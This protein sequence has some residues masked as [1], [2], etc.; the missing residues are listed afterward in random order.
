MR[1]F[2]HDLGT[3][4]TAILLFASTAQAQT[5]PQGVQQGPSIAGI[6]EYSYPNGLRVLLLPDPGSSAITVNI[7]YLVGSRHEN[8][9]ETG[10]AHLLE[11]LLFIESTTGRNI[12]EE[13]DDHGARWNGTTWFDRTNYFETVNASDENL[14]WALDLEAERMVHMRVDREVLEAE[15]TVVRN[16]FER[17]ENRPTAVLE[18][19]VF[20]TAYLWHNY[21][22]STIGARSDIENVTPERVAAFYATYYQP[23]NA[24]VTIAGPIDPSETLA[25]VAATLGAI[26]RPQRILDATYTVEPPQDGER[27]VDL[28]RAGSGQNL[29]IAYHI[30][31]RAHPDV[32]ALA[33]LADILTG[34]GTG[35]LNRSLEDTQKALSV[36][37]DV[38]ELHD[39]GL[40]V[41][42]ATLNDQ[43]SLDEVKAVIFD[44]LAGLATAPPTAEEVDRAKT[45]I[46]QGIDRTLADARRLALRLNE[47]IASG[48]WR[49][50][51]TNY[52]QVRQVASEDVQGVAARYFKASNR[53]VGAFIA[54]ATPDRTLVPEA[55][56]IA[57]LLET[58]T[59]DI[60]VAAGEA[61][62][63]APVNLENRIER[64]TVNEGIRVALVPKDTR[65][66]RVAA[67]LTLRFGDEH[68][69]VGQR[70]VSD[71]ANALLMRG[72]QTKSRQAIQDEM[73]RLNATIRVSG[74]RSSATASIA[75]TEEHFVPALRL[76]VEIL[77]EPAFPE[78]DFDQIRS[79]TI[80]RIE[81]GKAEPGI[82]APQTLQ[83]TLNPYPRDNVRYVPTSDEEI[84]ELERVTLDDVRRFH[85]A[86]YGASTGELVVVGT[87]EAAAVEAAAEEVLGS[88]ETPNPYSPIVD[89]YV[90][91]ESVNVQIDTPDKE[92]AQISA[93]LRFAMSDTHADYAAMVLANYMFGGGG[94]TARLPD[95]VRNREGLSY[96][97]FS[98]FSAPVEGDAATFSASAIANPANVPR[99]EASFIEEL[100]RT[101][102]EGFTAEEL[103]SAKRALLDQ[104]I[105]GRSSDGGL[106]N[107]I[108]VRER[109]GRTL[110]WDA[111]LDATLEALTLEQ[112]NAAFRR[113]IDPDALS[114]VKGGDFTTAGSA[115]A[116]PRVP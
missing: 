44:V 35:R 60:E 90:N 77:R 72:T 17:G 73:Q 99:V 66:A 114:I 21:G 54:E 100:T 12:K 10:M 41:L 53:T 20:S 37:A 32:A 92:N 29:M 48:D 79:Q 40:M 25:M 43:Q 33:V 107:L 75:T 101:L 4:M 104:R 86:F 8:Y 71:L 6:T 110:Q 76:A 18:E 105:G 49:L 2:A 70:A 96:S 34:A 56:G 38:N 5:L 63:P 108:A 78:P 19:R 14:R 74:G 59:P 39:P 91:I 47:T 102:A 80:A 13:L 9:S 28:R 15:M 94:L 85:E 11:H 68:S 27:T 116:G 84:A 65:G 30:P 89:N 69:L 83:R 22:K 3:S 98:R 57:T 58:Y 109:W 111:E 42:S 23:D 61:L 82:L 97:V 64:S 31:P 87:V 103:V 50:M 67:S 115:S 95:R 93:G 26:P 52:E 112:V 62:D 81:R 36:D 51:F 106:L 24:V 1:R 113:H 88:W 46:L 55:P 16:E 7:T 45:R